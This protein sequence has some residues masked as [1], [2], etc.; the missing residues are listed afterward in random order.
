MNKIK[1]KR[2]ELGEDLK[3]PGYMSEDAA[4]IDI[5]AGH[6]SIIMPLQTVMIRTGFA[7]EIPLG[8][9]LQCRSRSGLASQGIIVTNSPGTI[10]SDYRG[11]I[12]VLLTNINGSHSF[13]IQKG[14][15]IAQLVLAEVPKIEIEEVTELSETPRGENGFGSTGS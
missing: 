2:L 3:L 12:K 10:D 1:F 15:R 11:E 8:Y 4:G 6:N 14:D 7:V 13:Y 9:E 5:A